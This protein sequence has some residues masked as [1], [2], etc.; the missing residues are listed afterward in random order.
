MVE[1]AGSETASDGDSDVGSIT[2]WIDSLKAGDSSAAQALWE[3]YF[4][5]LVRM[6]A[7]RL[8]NAPGTSAV[9]GEESAALSAIESVCQGAKQGRFPQLSDREDLWQ[10]LVVV[11]ARKVCDQIQR[12]TAQKRGGGWVASPARLHTAEA[13]EPSPEFAAMCAD[14][15]R[16]LLG[17]L[18]DETYR[19]VAIWKMEGFTREEIGK[20]LN[21]STRTIA[22]RLEVIRRTWEG[23]VR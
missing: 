2:E 7:A 1:G 19:N 8:R 21:C 13:R 3:R 18:K 23:E 20:R 17:M 6:A 14:E 16:R 11:T 5:K 9:D 15:Y 12:R 10:I 4:N 22:D